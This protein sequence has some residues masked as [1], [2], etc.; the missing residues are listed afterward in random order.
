M[1]QETVKKMHEITKNYNNIL[2]CL[3]INHT[4]EHVLK[5]LNLYSP[6]IEIGVIAC[7]RYNYRRYAKTDV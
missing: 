4:H 2:I 1:S 6:L 3:D 7:F 5:E